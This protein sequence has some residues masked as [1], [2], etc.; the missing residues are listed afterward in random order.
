MVSAAPGPVDREAATDS[1]ETIVV[2]SQQRPWP[3]MRP[4]REQDAAFYFGRGAEIEDLRART[5]RSLLTLLYARGGLGKT[6]LLR[7][8]L[9]P[10]LV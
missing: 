9:T 4:Y 3:G 1:T 2:L 6:S 8:G 7:A 5:E 10:R